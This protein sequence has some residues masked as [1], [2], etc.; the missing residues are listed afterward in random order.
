MRFVGQPVRIRG[1]AALIEG[2]KQI[3]AVLAGYDRDEEAV[4][5]DLDGE[6]VA[7][8][9]SAVAKAHLRYQFDDGK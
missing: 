5:L 8:P 7:V 1:Y 9:L 2:R 6:R 3:D 4:L